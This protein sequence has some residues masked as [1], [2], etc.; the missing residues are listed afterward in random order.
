MIFLEACGGLCN[1]LRTIAS[2]KEFISNNPQY[3]NKI[4]V[5]WGLNEECN[6]KFEKL[7]DGIDGIKTINYAHKYS[8]LFLGYRFIQYCLTLRKRA[9]IDIKSEAAITVKKGS[10]FIRTG[11]P[12]G[13]AGQYQIFEPKAGIIA[14]VNQIVGSEGD[15][16][17]VHLRRTDNV[18]SI[19][20]SPIELFIEKMDAAIES[21]PNCKFFLATDSPDEEKQLSNR[22]GDRIIINDKKDLS[23]N[24]QEG[25][26]DALVD[27]VCLSRCRVIY[28]SYF[29]SF[30]IAASQWH[31]SDD[32][33]CTL[34]IRK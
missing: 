22:Y 1:R 17:G 12:I 15:M 8:L 23:R 11:F 9:Y 4:V 7:F 34:R 14:K 3:G 28:G 33:L 2:T 21:N 30:S 10:I 27:L 13:D 20:Q 24:S 19:M 5:L 32:C 6:C 18:K 16:I 25:I 26:Q 31:R 29:S